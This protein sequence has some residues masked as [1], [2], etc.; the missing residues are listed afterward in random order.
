MANGMLFHSIDS[1]KMFSFWTF[2][3]SKTNIFVDLKQEKNWMPY[4]L[5]DSS[6]LMILYSVEP[7]IIFECPTDH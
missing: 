4:L 7:L 3:N 1:F 6:D 5:K 2:F